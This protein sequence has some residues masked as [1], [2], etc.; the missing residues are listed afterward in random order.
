MADFCKHDH[1]CCGVT[2]C[3]TGHFHKITKVESCKPMFLGRN[4]DHVHY[5]SGETSKDD[6]H[7]HNVCYYT[8]PALP[9]AS[10]CGHYHYFYGITTCEDGHIHYYRGMTDI[11]ELTE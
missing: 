6:K 9:S 7:R 3:Y 1:E 8:G 2:D 5:Y 11:Y 4:V 10:G